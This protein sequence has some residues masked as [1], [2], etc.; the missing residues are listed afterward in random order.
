M[1]KEELKQELELVEQK[2]RLLLSDGRHRFTDLMN[3]MCVRDALKSS[4]IKLLEEE[5]RKAA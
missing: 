4:L 1:S 2:I 5:P 3:L